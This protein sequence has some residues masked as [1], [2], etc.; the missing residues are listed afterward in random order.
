MLGFNKKLDLRED[1]LRCIYVHTYVVSNFETSTCLSGVNSIHKF[2]YG[3]EIHKKHVCNFFTSMV[4]IESHGNGCFKRGK[5]P[6]PDDFDDYFFIVRKFA[7]GPLNVPGRN[8]RGPF[9]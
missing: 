2:I 5:Y 4:L 7:L 3:I 6:I 9:H 1:F 8:P